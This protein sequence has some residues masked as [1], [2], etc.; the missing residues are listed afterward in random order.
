MKRSEINAIYLNARTC[1]DRNGWTLPPNPRWDIT[2]F[3][4]GQYRKFGLVLVS[5][6]EE[7]EYCEKLMYA[8]KGM[9]T[10]AHCHARKKEDII[11]RWG[12]LAITFWNG[13][14]VGKTAP[15]FEIQV[16]RVKRPMA[17]QEALILSAGQRVTIPPGVY[18]EFVPLSHECI[19]GQ[20]STADD[21]ENDNFFA[22]PDVRRFP[23]IEEDEKSFVRLISD[24]Q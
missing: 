5:L 19:L 12:D 7:P 8:Q 4:L 20:I 18:H 24:P 14:P 21:D 23:T 2:D 1:F 9:T 17:S 11:C 22:N 13:K 3:G 10:P 16:D 6:C 15:P